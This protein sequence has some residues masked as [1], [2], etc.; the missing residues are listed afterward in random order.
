MTCIES[1]RGHIES[2]HAEA[3][4]DD[5]GQVLNVIATEKA[6]AHAKYLTLFETNV[7]GL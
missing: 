3:F 2:I 4:T 6:I 1:S 7:N 5:N